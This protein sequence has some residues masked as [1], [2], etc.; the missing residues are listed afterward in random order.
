MTRPAPW[1]PPE[2]DRCVSV[3]TSGRATIRTGHYFQRIDGVWVCANCGTT[4]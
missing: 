3:D 2:P 1:L 4:R